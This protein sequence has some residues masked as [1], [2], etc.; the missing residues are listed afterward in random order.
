MD[1]RG[2]PPWLG[3]ADDDGVVRWVRWRFTVLGVLAARP[4]LAAVAVVA[5]PVADLADLADRSHRFERHYTWSLVG[6]VPALAERIIAKLRRKVPK[7]ALLV[8]REVPGEIEGKRDVI[9]E[10]YEVLCGLGHSESEA[11]RLVD[12]VIGTK[13]KFTDVQELLQVIYDKSK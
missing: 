11:R 6:P 5:Y 3:D 1:R 9:G 7:F 8:A 2:A 10:T 12:N 13:K 4:E